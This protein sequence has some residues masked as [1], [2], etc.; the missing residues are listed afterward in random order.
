MIIKSID[1]AR[2]TI[3]IREATLADAVQFRELRLFALQESPTAFSAD[4]EINFN[5]P[6]SF[7][8]GRLTFDEHGTIFFVEQDSLLIGM[9]GIRK[10]ESP[11]T[12]HGAYIWGV[13]IR[14]EWRGLHIAEELIKSCIEWAKARDVEIVK[15]GVMTTNASA[16]RCYERCG[17]T[18]YGTEPRCI[19]YEGM[20]CDEFLMYRD[21]T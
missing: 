19:F 7:W 9:A 1:T 15:L 13:Y 3:I 2:G 18:I 11:K 10:G 16:V 14:P 6:M 8:E 12:K 21:I 4:Y 5:H 17:F 20:Y